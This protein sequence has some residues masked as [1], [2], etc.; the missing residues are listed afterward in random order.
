MV[1]VPEN[2]APQDGLTNA[3]IKFVSLFVEGNGAVIHFEMT[4]DEGS[5]VGEFPIEVHPSRVPGVPQT[6]DSLISSAHRDMIDVLRQWIYMLDVSAKVYE[7]RS[8]P[9]AQE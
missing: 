8:A 6:A 7:S 2:L 9:P 1:D 5:A 4:D 3:K